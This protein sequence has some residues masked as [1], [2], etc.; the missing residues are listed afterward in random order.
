MTYVMFLK[1]KQ[2]YHCINKISHES[3][4]TDR[5]KSNKMQALW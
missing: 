2:W 1:I 5:R 3:S 4:K